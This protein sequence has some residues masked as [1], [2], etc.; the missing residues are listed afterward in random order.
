MFKF[1]F[2]LDA[3]QDKTLI[4]LF[5]IQEDKKSFE[6]VDMPTINIDMDSYR[7]NVNLFLF[8]RIR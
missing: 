5:N 1:G 6:P 8:V 3:K 2:T 4:K 7:L